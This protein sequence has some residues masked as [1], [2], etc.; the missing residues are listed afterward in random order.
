M[1][2]SKKGPKFNIFWE[3]PLP[4]NTFS[5]SSIPYSIYF[6]TILILTFSI[7]SRRKVGIAKEGTFFS[8][9]HLLDQNCPTSLC[10]HPLLTKT[11]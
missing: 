10:L 4:S 9:F 6:V 8:S 7:R 3:K 2:H 11:Q 1:A 5:D